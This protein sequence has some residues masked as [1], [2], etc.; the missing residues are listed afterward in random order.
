MYP[1]R[2][3]IKDES[4]SSNNELVTANNNQHSFFYR[5]GTKTVIYTG[6]AGLVSFL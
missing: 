1:A 2:H 5:F 3:D 6:I 4:L